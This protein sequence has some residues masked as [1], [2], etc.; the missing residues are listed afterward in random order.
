M[1]FFDKVNDI[2][3]ALGVQTVYTVVFLTLLVLYGDFSEGPA[4]RLIHFGPSNEEID[5]SILGFK[6]TTK[7]R[8]YTI[9]AMLFASAL[10]ST[11]VYKVYS[12]WLSNIVE[13]PKTLV[14]G[15]PKYVVLIIINIMDLF[16]WSIGTLGFL[17]FLNT[18]MIQFMI[19][20]FIAALLIG[21]VSNW[22]YMRHKTPYNK[23]TKK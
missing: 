17:V 10:L 22:G 3:I 1:G 7:K 2:R 6:V 8:L 23:K 9:M 14:L 18:Q 11:Y 16:G 20:E 19:P 4:K 15:M 13:D 5:I 21:N 12:P